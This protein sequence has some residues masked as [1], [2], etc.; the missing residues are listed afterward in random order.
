MAKTH[1]VYWKM[2]QSDLAQFE[3]FFVGAEY[4]NRKAGKKVSNWWDDQF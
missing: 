3:C 4:C 1:K 2:L